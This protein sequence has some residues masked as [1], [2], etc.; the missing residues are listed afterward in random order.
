MHKNKTIIML[1]LVNQLRQNYTSEAR[2]HARRA[3]SESKG[4]SHTIYTYTCSYIF[5]VSRGAG[6]EKITSTVPIVRVKTIIS[7]KCLVERY[8][9]HIGCIYKSC[10]SFKG[11]YI[12]KLLIS[13]RMDGKGAS[14]IIT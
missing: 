12:L 9:L 4:T 8:L 2:G 11:S 3:Y 1:G 13:L 14:N 5:E 10:Q 6:L 7:Q